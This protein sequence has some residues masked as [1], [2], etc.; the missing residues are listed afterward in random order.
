[1]FGNFKK[2]VASTNNKVEP[3][4][5]IKVADTPWER[6]LLNRFHGAPGDAHL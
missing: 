3:F 5:T 2:P 1:L 4:T 6:L